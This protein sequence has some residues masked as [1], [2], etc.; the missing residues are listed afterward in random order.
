MFLGSLPIVSTSYAFDM[1]GFI[2]DVS[3]LK[4]FVAHMSA[5]KELVAHFAGVCDSIQKVSDIVHVC[6]AHGCVMI[7]HVCVAHVC[8]TKS[9]MTLVS[10]LMCPTRKSSWPTCLPR[11]SSWLV[12][13]A[14]IFDDTGLIL[15]ASRVR[16]LIGH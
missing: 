5:L 11:K 13:L 10:F 3:A 1:T 14:C 8:M 15:D 9:L 16:H 4:E 12:S 7:V 6:V 2:L